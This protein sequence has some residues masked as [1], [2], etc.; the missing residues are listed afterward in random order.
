MRDLEILTYCL[1]AFPGESVVDVF[2]ALD[3]PGRALV[4]TF[5]RE[6]EEGRATRWGL[7]STLALEI[8]WE[9]LSML[10]PGPFQQGG[11]SPVLAVVVAAHA[12]PLDLEP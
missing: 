8:Q 2:A 1:N 7:R 4:D 5:R 6:G 9:R 3:G 11:M 10:Q 12:A